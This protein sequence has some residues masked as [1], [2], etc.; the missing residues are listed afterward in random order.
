VIEA[1]VILVGALAG[2]CGVYVAAVV[3]ARRAERDRNRPTAGLEALER[4]HRRVNRG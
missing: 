4:A 1:V 3:A 2:A